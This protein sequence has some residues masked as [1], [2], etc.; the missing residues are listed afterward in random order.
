MQTPARWDG[1]REDKESFMGKHS[2]NKFR[3]L[4]PASQFCGG[5]GSSS[6][7]SHSSTGTTPPVTGTG[8]TGTGG[9]VGP[10]VGT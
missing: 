8:G 6:S 2:K 5:R 9:G 3:G 7:S 4:A 1:R 10:V